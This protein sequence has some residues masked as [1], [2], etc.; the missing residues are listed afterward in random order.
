MDAFIDIGVLR[1]VL[2]DFDGY[3][4]TTTGRAD[5]SVRGF[6]WCSCVSA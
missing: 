6:N 5:V 1:M 2:G 4:A 3:Q